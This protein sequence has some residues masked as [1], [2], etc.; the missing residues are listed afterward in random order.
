[1][2]RLSRAK[3]CPSCGHIHAV[4]RRRK[5]WQRLFANSGLYRCNRCQE[6]YLVLGCC[7]KTERSAVN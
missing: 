4:S 7:P 3:M 2:A 5:G 1:M 6:E